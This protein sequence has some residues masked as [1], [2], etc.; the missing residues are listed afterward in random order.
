MKVAVLLGLAFAAVAAGMAQ[1]VPVDLSG[2]W[3]LLLTTSEYWSVPF[4]GEQRRV[5]QSVVRL[6]IEQNGFELMLNEFRYCLALVDTGTPFVRVN[7]SPR[8]YSSIR[9]GPVQG[10]LEQDSETFQLVVPPFVAL[11]GVRL[12]DP[13]SERLPQNPSDPRVVDSDGDGKPGVTTQITV[14][15]LIS[16]EA[17]VVQRSMLSLKGTVVSPDLIQG[18]LTWKDEQV[19]LAATS[20]FLVQSAQGRPDPV[21]ENSYFIL[22]RI[23]GNKTCEEIIALFADRLRR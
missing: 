1:E 22:R 10:R 14:L 21:L 16:G 12:S 18:L 5:G 2:S 3:A 8:F 6:T 19:T 23:I 11:N 4:M 7:I 17:Y 9:V 20:S 13:F 15:G